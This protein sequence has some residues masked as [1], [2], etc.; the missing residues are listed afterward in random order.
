MKKYS[1]KV[2]GVRFPARDG[3]DRQTTLKELFEKDTERES[4]LRGHNVKFEGYDYKGDDA[5]AVFVD[6]REIGNISADKVQEVAEIA[7]KASNCKVILSVNG[8]D[9]DE[10]AYIVDRHKNKKEWKESDPY[11]DGEEADEEYNA[12][13][14]E[15]KE[16]AIYSAVLQLS[17]PE[18]GDNTNNTEEKKKEKVNKEPAKGTLMFEFILSIVLI[19]MSAVLLLAK[20]IAGVIGIIIGVYILI[21]SRK[22]LKKI[23]EKEQATNKKE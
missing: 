15:I 8:R 2:V 5:L 12:L 10:Y 7:Q 17:I 20:P 22:N 1:Y 18:E 4:Y 23:K 11:F 14:E 9:V 21:Y 3:S 16:E 19:L 13:M 6:G